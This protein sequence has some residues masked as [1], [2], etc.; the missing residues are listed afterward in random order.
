MKLN[1]CTALIML[2][3]H[4]VIMSLSAQQYKAE[5]TEIDEAIY[6]LFSSELYP[7]LALSNENLYKVFGSTIVKC[8][9][10]TQLN[11][12][13][14]E[15]SVL[16]SGDKE[17]L[18]PNPEG[19]VISINFSDPK[20]VTIAM[21]WDKTQ[22]QT[23][24]Y[25]GNGYFLYSTSDGIY[26]RRFQSPPIKILDGERIITSMTPID[27][28][29]NYIFADLNSG[30]YGT[31]GDSIANIFQQSGVTAIDFLNQTIYMNHGGVIKRLSKKGGMRTLTTLPDRYKSASHLYYDND[32][33]IWIQSEDLFAF[34]LTE[35]KLFT[36]HY[37][38]NAISC[39]DAITKNGVTYIATNKGLYTFQRTLDKI[40]HLKSQQ[41]LPHV[42]PSGKDNILVDN[43]NLYTLKSKYTK[44]LS[45][46]TKVKH[47]IK[48][49]DGWWIRRG[50]KLLKVNDRT[51]PS[52]IAPSDSVTVINTIDPATYAVG[53]TKGIY[54]K[55]GQK[56]DY[57]L[58]TLKDTSINDLMKGQSNLLL[59]SSPSGMHSTD[60]IIGHSIKLDSDRYCAAINMELYG[61][62]TLA[63]CKEAIHIL[64]RDTVVKIKAKEDLYISQILDIELIN[65]AL[66]IL[67]NNQLLKGE[68]QA[69]R[70]GNA[71]QFTRYKTFESDRGL[72]T[73]Q[74]GQL[75][76]ETPF[77]VS[78]IHP[79]RLSTHQIEPETEP[80]FTYEYIDKALKIYDHKS[81]DQSK[82]KYETEDGEWVSVE[83]NE[84]SFKTLSENGLKV[85]KKNLYGEWIP[86]KIK[87]VT[88][89]VPPRQSKLGWILISL[90]LIGMLYLLKLK[91][92][93]D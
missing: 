80:T 69:V 36:I 19:G 79:N 5:P 63:I 6:H 62:D 40:I 61:G 73:Y 33:N 43:G 9:L 38:D 20:Q 26:R 2:M 56:A 92:L 10:P 90:G 44:Q 34:N 28:L 27:D 45:T 46:N 17:I 47:P 58:H 1:R 87:P 52:L 11:L 15:N 70:N 13:G 12:T 32:Y 37:G 76:I 8:E 51:T 31:Y 74:N 59:S 48:S 64:S 50:E 75:I 82:M 23:L 22:L 78:I 77:D 83:N 39:H 84:I 66:Y 81:S 14:N 65:D 68:Y 89:I 55:D 93:N 25:N 42:Y 41:G 71:S 18:I 35:N 3:I 21:D 86:L 29:G 60:L 7:C 67:G 16:L 54:L 72:L 4:C 30:I 91:F 53:T 88:M 85:Q 49:K 57:S 24:N